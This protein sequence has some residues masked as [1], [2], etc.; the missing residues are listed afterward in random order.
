MGTS[1][2][3]DLG[4]VAHDLHLPLDK[5][6][7]T[8]ELLDDGNTV[9]FITRYRKDAT[10]GLDEEQIRLIQDAVGKARALAERKQTI[11]KSIEAQGKLTAEL[12]QRIQQAP[13][14]KQLEDLYLPYKP[15][16]QSL[17]T[18]A[19]ERGLEPLA[20]E[21]L[22][23]DPKA[24]DLNA[25]AADFVN[26]D[27]DV[28]N[29]A[30]ALM[31]VGHLIAERYSERAD[32]RGKLRRI[33]RS[34]GQLVSI[35]VE[36]SDEDDA[37]EGDLDESAVEVAETDLDDEDAGDDEISSEIA[38]DEQDADEPTGEEPNAEAQSADTSDQATKPTENAAEPTANPAESASDA[39]TSADSASAASES[40][41]GES[42][43]NVPAPSETDMDAASSETTATAALASESADAIPAFGE[44]SGSLTGPVVKPAK[45]PKLSKQARA[46]AAKAAARAAKK[47]RKRQ[48]L[49]ASFKDYFN[50][51]ESIAKIPPHRVLAINRGERVKIL[52][53]K[54]EFDTEQMLAA[55]TEMLIPAEQPHA[56]F[57]R[58]CL[59]DAL[60]RLIV[61]SLEREARREL[62]DAA[63]THAVEVFA[64]NLRKLLLQPPVRGRRVLAMDP[65]FR[66]GV[67]IVTL[68]EFG[69]VLAHAL[70]HV[71]GS[72]DRVAEGRAKLIEF[73]RTDEIDV[74]AI[75][76]GTGC[77]ETELMVADV[78]ANE[79]ADRELAYVIVNE[80]GASVYST[81]ELG[82]EELPDF[83]ATQRG[84]ISIGRRLLDPLSELVKITPA[85]IGVG[86]YQHDVKAKHL[87]ESLDAVVE[88]CVNYVGVDVNSASPA[89]LGYVSGLN[90]LT[91]RRLYQYRR[92]H[93]PFRSREQLKEVP[94][95]GDATFVQSAGFLKIVDGENPLDATPI[96]PES[97]EVAQ[98]VLERL[99]SNVEQLRRRIVRHQPPKTI[100]R[101]AAATTESPVASQVPENEVPENEV[102]AE[103]FAVDETP[104]S[105]EAPAQ[106][107]SAPPVEAQAAEA[108]TLEAQTAETPAMEAATVEDA[109][110]EAP[111]DETAGA[112]ML[113]GF[114]EAAKD[115]DQA[116]RPAN[117]VV[118][119]E[120]LAARVAAVNREQFAEEMNV[121]KLLLSDILSSLLRP[122]R[123]PREDFPPPVFRREVM[124]LE[125]LEPGM[126]LSGS[127]LNV[128]DF[129]AFIDI[130]LSE[131]GLVH[132]SR[133]A[134]R[135]VRDPHEVVAVGDVL[136]VWVMEVDKQRR[137]VSLTAIA[138][139]SEKPRQPRGPARPATGEPRRKKPVREQRAK[140]A[141]GHGKPSRSQRP[142]KS[143]VVKPRVPAPPITQ[144]MVEGKEPMRSF[145]DL[146]QFY[147]KKQEPGDK[148]PKKS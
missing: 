116:V 78:I 112:A 111:T 82:R 21:I 122:S 137:R 128:V 19:R 66:S 17:A 77:R 143:K 72:E 64:R 47:L 14:T 91:A 1:V 4:R 54:I 89:L 2:S 41:G 5:V 53:V 15:K 83:D 115:E 45:P 121:G 50:F 88:S 141:H 42:V 44:S 7:R 90:Q 34:S 109:N 95:I 123:D 26:P 118:D 87:Q 68:N 9:P 58:G 132:I 60:F 29:V 38:T 101:Q 146:L 11:L 147:S 25:R 8:V 145:S 125:D 24:A 76:N 108:P 136:K 70:I 119:S 135:F 69:N 12:A 31:G 117:E 107:A 130:G 52:R 96:H 148:P 16:K 110:A 106:S 140:P 10:G 20:R 37:T 85:N 35:R 80:A 113:P 114:E 92:E 79:L 94:G 18:Q 73:I 120:Q 59:R 49:E 126:E 93:G 43:A 63:E 62:T 144:D 81:S 129:G 57:L 100:E 13:S 65:G 74:V 28:N 102:A 48:K 131:P 133:L 55:A 86:L 61:P 105:V 98:N 142:P 32:V 33:M 40:N 3:I 51:R 67:K 39:P 75:G 139:G 56:D 36:P 46:K 134:D 71:I 124:K 27:R 104:T 127:I 84:A 22:D 103:T 30:E 97:Y 6:Q 99:G 23:A 138:P